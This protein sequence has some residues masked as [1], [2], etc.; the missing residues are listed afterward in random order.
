MG[1]D[2]RPRLMK[3]DERVWCNGLLSRSALEQS[4]VELVNAQADAPE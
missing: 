1:I 4:P 3:Q 2:L